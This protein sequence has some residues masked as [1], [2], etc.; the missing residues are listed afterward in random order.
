MFRFRTLRLSG[1]RLA[2]HPC[3]LSL[4]ALSQTVRSFECTQPLETTP[5]LYP[6]LPWITPPCKKQLHLGPPGSRGL[7]CQSWT[8]PG[9][10]PIQTLETGLIQIRRGRRGPV[11]LEHGVWVLCPP[12]SKV[13][14]LWKENLSQPGRNIAG[15]N[16]VAPS[17]VESPEQG[18]H[19]VPI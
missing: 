15:R 14:S 9:T 6:P 3:S 8:D 5:K 1:H 7:C 16:T 2:D 18:F 10:R 17:K 4:L 12:D 13:S 19:F 11:H